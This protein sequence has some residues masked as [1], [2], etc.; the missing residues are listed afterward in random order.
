[1]PATVVAIGT[2]TYHMMCILV[3][4]QPFRINASRANP[5]KYKIFVPLYFPKTSKKY[6]VAIIYII[7]NVLDSDW[8]HLLVLRENLN[9]K[10]LV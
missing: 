1:M 3:L 9:M 2:V 10:I 6:L 7:M 5:I 4:Y 8:K